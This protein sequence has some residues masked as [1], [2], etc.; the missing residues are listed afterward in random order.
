MSE[1]TVDK[2]YEKK[3]VR[4]VIRHIQDIHQNSD[5]WYRSVDAKSLKPGQFVMTAMQMSSNLEN[6]VGFCVQVR[7]RS[8]QFGSDMVFLRHYNGKLITHENQSFYSLNEE[9]EKLAREI[10]EH[11]PEDE[12]YSHG[13]KCFEGIEEKGFMIEHS[14]SKG[15]PD[16]AFSITITSQDG[17][18]EKN[19][20]VP[21]SKEDKEKK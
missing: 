16:T 10:F 13:Y 8:G 6:Y 9:Q 15:T 2:E 5:G 1:D 19:I 20:F 21:L 17:H 3:Y 18:V 12:D 11:L 7:R 4:A 14:E